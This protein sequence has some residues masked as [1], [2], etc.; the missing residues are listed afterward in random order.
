MHTNRQRYTPQS[1]F[2]KSNIT[3]S[4]KSLFDEKFEVDLS[5]LSKENQSL[6]SLQ[7]CVSWTQ[8]FSTLGIVSVN[9]IHSWIALK[10]NLN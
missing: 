10:R 2:Y 3:D 7:L 9:I 8:F 6:T 5:A 1:T 4:T